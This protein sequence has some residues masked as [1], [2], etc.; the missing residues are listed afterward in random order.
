MSD[1][2]I[3]KNIQ[4]FYKADQD[5]DGVVEQSD[6]AA[7]GERVALALGHR[8]GT[9]EA[10]KCV[11]AITGLWDTY[12]A[13][14]DSDRDGRV[15]LMEWLGTQQA[16][17]GQDP[18]GFRKAHFGAHDKLFEAM[19]SSGNGKISAKEY[20][21]FVS[22]GLNVPRSSAETAF[23][24]LDADG[25]GQLS[26]QEFGQLIWDYHNSVDQRAA[27]NQFYGGY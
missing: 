27:G 22:A 2:M 4:F 8:P 24:V 11:A 7:A 21:A 19:D 3:R 13:A 16:M 18:E 6:F 20:L 25:D 5:R 15:T 26:K 14:A 1:F 17:V 10:E 9:A 23:P 12:W